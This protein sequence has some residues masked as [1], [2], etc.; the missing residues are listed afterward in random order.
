MEELGVWTCVEVFGSSV[1]IGWMFDLLYR[2]TKA[3]SEG[4]WW[5]NFNLFPDCPQGDNFG[6]I[7]LIHSWSCLSFGQKRYLISRGPECHKTWAAFE[8]GRDETKQKTCGNCDYLRETTWVWGEGNVNRSADCR[9]RGQYTTAIAQDSRALSWQHP[10]RILPTEPG[11]HILKWNMV[12]CS[13]CFSA[14]NL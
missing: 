1:C 12:G 10:L 11:E 9:L 13:V 5:W 7:S 3:G 4:Y 14:S 8:V 2:Y 6:C